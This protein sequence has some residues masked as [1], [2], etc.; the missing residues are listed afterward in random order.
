MSAHL[1]RVAV[2]LG[3]QTS[4]LSITL[5]IHAYIKNSNNKSRRTAEMVIKDLRLVHDNPFLPGQ[6][7]PLICNLLHRLEKRLHGKG[8]RHGILSMRSALSPKEVDTLVSRLLP[9]DRDA[10]VRLTEIVDELEIMLR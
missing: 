3:G 10:I 2:C 4:L 6:I 7:Q 1:R 9:W 5:D 8:H